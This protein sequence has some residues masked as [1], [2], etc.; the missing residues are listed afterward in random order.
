ME[1]AMA[2]RPRVTVI[3]ESPGGWNQRFHDNRTGEGMTRAGFVR[4]IE[5]GNY[6]AI[7]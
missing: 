5:R 3:Q 6:P 2:K 1:L 7:E 4:E